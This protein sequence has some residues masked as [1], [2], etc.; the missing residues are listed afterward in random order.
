MR[1]LKD[2]LHA[3]LPDATALGGGS[4]IDR[5]RLL[6]VLAELST[7]LTRAVWLR[8]LVA[9]LVLMLLLALAWRFAG[10]PTLLLGTLAVA[11][12]VLM[13]ALVA[14]KQVTDEIARLELVRSIASTV[15]VESLTE[16]ARRMVMST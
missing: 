7:L 13:A 5:E 11:F 10:H 15:S 14:V 6:S 8:A 12:I 1:T 16:I 2:A 4:G 9:L 3:A